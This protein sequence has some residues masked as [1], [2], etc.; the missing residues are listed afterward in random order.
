MSSLA[1]LVQKQL[2]P[3]AKKNGG[4]LGEYIQQW[5]A[6]APQF[7]S[8]STP[9]KIKAGVLTLAVDSGS[10][11]QRIKLQQMQILTSLNGHFGHATVTGIRT[12][13]QP[14]HIQK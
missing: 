7:A 11:A 6:L 3:I 2:K 12:I 8:F 1:S 10:T 5:S 4:A 9:Y 14:E 13:I